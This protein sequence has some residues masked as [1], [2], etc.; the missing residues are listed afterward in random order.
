MDIVSLHQHNAK[1][2]NSGWAGEYLVVGA[3]LFNWD[4]DPFWQYPG[5]DFH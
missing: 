1:I 5:I 2:E 3:T 4:D